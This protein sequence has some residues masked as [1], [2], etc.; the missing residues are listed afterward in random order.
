MTLLRGIIDQAWL[1][2]EWISENYWVCYVGMVIVMLW[3]GLSRDKEDNDIGHQ[4]NTGNKRQGFA[5]SVRP[6]PGVEKG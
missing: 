1:L 3:V 6:P 5:R 2:G 4:D